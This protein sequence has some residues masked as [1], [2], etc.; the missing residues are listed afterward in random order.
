MLDSP[1]LSHEPEESAARFAS[2]IIPSRELLA[3]ARAQASFRAYFEQFGPVD[4]VIVKHPAA[5]MWLRTGNAMDYRSFGFVTVHGDELAQ[6]LMSM[7][8]EIDGDTVGTPELAKQARTDR[9][10]ARQARAGMAPAPGV[11]TSNPSGTGAWEP[12]MP[13]KIFVGG[14]SH[15]TKESSLQVRDAPLHTPCP[16][17]C[18]CAQ[19]PDGHLPPPPARR[20]TFRSSARSPTWSS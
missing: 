18:P 11:E 13:K 8:H 6:K 12:S 1:T 2:A 16:R 15:Q 4:K 3:P 7:T 14:L 20:G 19:C 5:R 17:S 10:A 9:N